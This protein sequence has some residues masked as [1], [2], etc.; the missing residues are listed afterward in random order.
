MYS[1]PDDPI[2]P[3]HRWWR[4]STTLLSLACCGVFAAR[5]IYEMMRALPPGHTIGLADVLSL[6]FGLLPS[7]ILA[8]ITGLRALYP[9]LEAR[10]AS[11]R[12]WRQLLALVFWMLL[13]PA[14]GLLD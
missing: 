12:R 14:I 1:V 5:V 10:T 8:W 4:I 3:R 2:R 11:G 13:L 6:L 7:A 9:F